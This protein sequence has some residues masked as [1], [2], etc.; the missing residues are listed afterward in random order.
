MA[1]RATMGIPSSGREKNSMSSEAG[2][3]LAG[4]SVGRRVQQGGVRGRKEEGWPDGAG[5]NSSRW[6]LDLTFKGP[7]LG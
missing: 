7:V 6:I 2:W 5:E 1:N 4:A 3:D